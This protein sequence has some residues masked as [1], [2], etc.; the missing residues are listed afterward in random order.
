MRRFSTV[1]C[2][3]VVS[4]AAVTACGSSAAKTAAP[5]LTAADYIQQADA[6]CKADTAT[7]VAAAVAL[8]DSPTPQQQQQWVTASVVPLYSHTV[9][10]VGALT[11]P[12]ELASKVS[13]WLTVFKR[14]INEA[15]SNPASVLDGSGSLPTAYNRAGDVGLHEC[16]Q[17][18]KK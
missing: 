11:P 6:I 8:G 16:N 7:I 10:A 4:A 18:P 2:A 5:A 9:S 14:A 12:K 3:A 13:T 15:K 1:I 17:Q